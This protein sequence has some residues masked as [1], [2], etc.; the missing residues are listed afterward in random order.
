MTL[1]GQSDSDTPPW[2]WFADRLV[3][4]GF[5]TKDGDGRYRPTELSDLLDAVTS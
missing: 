2:D 4:D 5:L 1:P 3:T